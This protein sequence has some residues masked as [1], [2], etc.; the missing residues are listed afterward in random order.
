MLGSDEGIKIEQFHDKVV[1][2]ILLNV[3]GIPLGIDVITYLGSL[4]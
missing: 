3:D 1:G 2:T 4:D